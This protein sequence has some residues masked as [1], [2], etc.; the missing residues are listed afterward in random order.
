[1]YRLFAGKSLHDLENCVN[2]A[3][4]DGWVPQGPPTHLGTTVIQAMICGS[5]NKLDKYIK[6]AQSLHPGQCLFTAKCNMEL[7]KNNKLD[8]WKISDK[9]YLFVSDT[10]ILKLMSKYIIKKYPNPGPLIL[11]APVEPLEPGT[12]W[13]TI[14]T[15][16]N[17]SEPKSSPDFFPSHPGILL[18]PPPQLDSWSGTD[19]PPH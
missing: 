16:E 1:M 9:M 13:M 10:N 6:Y 18:P 5:E 8:F 2:F 19:N 15:K 17:S 7:E 4:A 12:E 11:P 14:A 3:M